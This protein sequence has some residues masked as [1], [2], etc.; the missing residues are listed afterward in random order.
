MNFM[1]IYGMMF[2]VGGTTM[3]R[4]KDFLYD[5]SDLFFSLLIIALIFFVVSLKLDATM[6]DTWFSGKTSTETQTLEFE[7][8]TPPDLNNPITDP[9]TVTPGDTVDPV[10]PD[11]PV[12]VPVVEI[13][14]VRFEILP[15]TSGYQIAAK[16]ESEKL[17]A[18]IDEF[19]QKL[20]EMQLG[21]KLRAGVHQL[22]TGMTV[23]EII[24]KLS[25]Q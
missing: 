14:D 20:G 4:V 2:H 11:E 21:N 12:D 3:E 10:E 13:R 6:V 16:L 23:E 15:G 22:N 17:I 24:L 1:V 19:T 18:S 9:N 25:G 5:I 7:E 8:S